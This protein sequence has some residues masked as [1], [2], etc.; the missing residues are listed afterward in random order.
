MAAAC[1]ESRLESARSLLNTP[2]VAQPVNAGNSTGVDPKKLPSTVKITFPALRDE[3]RREWP[4]LGSDEGVLVLYDGSPGIQKQGTTL[5]AQQTGPATGQW[6]ESAAEPK[7]DGSTLFVGQTRWWTLAP[8]RVTF[9]EGRSDSTAFDLR[10]TLDA[11][12]SE[13]VRI[14]FGSETHLL[15]H[16]GNALVYVR[17]NPA[18]DKF[19]SFSLP[20][21]H[22]R[23]EL[24]GLMVDPQN[25]FWIIRP[26]SVSFYE[27]NAERNQIEAQTAALSHNAG[28][29]FFDPQTTWVARGSYADGSL[30]LNQLVFRSDTKL[31]AAYADQFEEEPHPTGSDT[32]PTEVKGQSGADEEAQLAAVAYT[33]DF[34]NTRMKALAEAH[35]LPCHGPNAQGRTW[36]TAHEFSGWA[37]PEQNL[38]S[39]IK[40]GSMPKKG[41]PQESSLSSLDRQIMLKFAEDASAQASN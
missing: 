37:A 13:T 33:E 25:N 26:D 27:L 17:K 15:L 24:S 18:T 41:S 40:L 34:W 23:A 12:V 6:L 29:P 3:N 20:T 39:Y 32:N 1:A 8:P 14:V 31:A 7:K 9:T 36:T 35:C 2:P 38:A 11:N 4:E 21:D 30:A 19:L 5:Y 10:S 22:S 16:E 28:S